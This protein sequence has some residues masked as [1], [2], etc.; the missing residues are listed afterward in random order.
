MSYLKYITD[1]NLI[2]IV[3]DTLNAGIIKKKE[4]EKTFTKNVIDP[5]AAILEASA[6]NLDHKTWKD[7]ELARQCQKTLQNYIGNMH[8]A[9][10][11][12]V[13]NWEDLGVGNVIDL[14][15][16]DKKIIAE[17]KNKHNT[18]TGGKLADMYYSL[19]RLVT[20][21]NNNYYGYTIYFVNIV[22]KKP[23]RYNAPFTP[24]DKEKGAKCPINEKIRIIDGAS[25]FE[26]VTGEQN[27]L[28]N[29]Y[30]I[31]PKVIEDIFNKESHI[32]FQ[33]PDKEKFA[34]YFHQ[35]YS[36]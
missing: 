21:K 1:D 33:I 9:I 27:A 28:A 13:K 4:V 2:D 19:D 7:S 26:L 32:K 14:K 20:Y 15:N 29:F 18:V 12:K 22:P 10:L 23:N 5:F 35:A 31:L 30:N 6:F 24:S 16:K 25:F 3:K 34:D 11:G 8:Q 17:V 36:K